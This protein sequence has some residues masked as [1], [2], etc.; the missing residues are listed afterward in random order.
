MARASW[1]NVGVDYSSFFSDLYRSE[2]AKK[3]ETQAAADADARSRWAAGQMSDTEWLAY[4]A[5]RI[6][7]TV[8]DPSEHQKWVSLQRQ[9]TISIADAHA[10]SAYQQSGDLAAYIGYLESAAAGMSPGSQEYADRQAQ[11]A[12]YKDELF[13]QDLGK[14]RDEIV[15]RINEGDVSGYKDLVDLLVE[16]KSRARPGSP[17]STDIDN[18]LSTARSQQR[19]VQAKGGA[20]EI[21][22]LFLEN[23]ITGAEAARRLR[24][25]AETYYKADPVS[26]YKTR[27]NALEYAKYGN[28]FYKK[29]APSSGGSRSGGTSRSGSSG[30][31]SVNN[32]ALR[33]AG[34]DRAEYIQGLINNASPENPVIRIDG[35]SYSVFN[36]D[37]TYAAWVDEFHTQALGAYDLLATEQEASSK[38]S[39]RNKAGDTRAAKTKFI[40]K[41]VQPGN[42]LIGERI[43][44]Q[45]F[46]GYQKDLAEAQKSNDPRSTLN[47][48]ET[49]RNNLL[50]YRTRVTKTRNDKSVREDGR[51]DGSQNQWRSI[52]S[53]SPSA[54]TNQHINEVNAAIDL[55]TAALGGDPDLDNTKDVINSRYNLPDKAKF[56]PSKVMSS[57]LK[58]VSETAQDVACLDRGECALVMTP[59]GTVVVGSEPVTKYDATT[60]RTTVVMQPSKTKMN[61][62]LAKEG[63]VEF[64]DTYVQ[65]NGTLM[66]VPTVATP[67]VAGKAYRT[68]D[69]LTYKDEKGKSHVLPK[70]AL[71][72]SS[73][74][75]STKNDFEA[76]RRDRKV[77]LA[78]APSDWLVVTVP[79]SQDGHD[80][81]PTVQF[82]VDPRTGAWFDANSGAVQPR[83]AADATTVQVDEFG[84]VVMDLAAGASGA[85]MPSGFVG[86]DAR[87]MAAYVRAHPDEF[88]N[89]KTYDATGNA[90]PQ[91]GDWGRTYDLDLG[92]D[93]R[94]P[95]RDERDD[96]Y[97]L[98]QAQA[99]K[100]VEDARQAARLAA[101]KPPNVNAST[102]FN[103]NAAVGFEGLAN[104]LGITFGT[105]RVNPRFG[106]G[107]EA[108]G[109]PTGPSRASS[110][111]V[112]PA[113]PGAYDNVSS[114]PVVAGTGSQVTLK[115]TD[116]T[117]GKITLPTTK[118]TTTPT[119]TVSSSTGFT[120]P[121]TTGT[122][123]VNSSTGFVTGSKTTTSSKTTTAS[124]ITTPKATPKPTPKATTTTTSSR[125]GGK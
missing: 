69:K 25:L 23:K 108:L 59:R 122:P 96:A 30:G 41:N 125:R 19:D 4:I 110:P 8:D 123:V 100:R 66:K 91:T 63:G 61:E 85:A 90:I 32:I 120:V 72:P 101:S 115:P 50:A 27:D 9:D 7:A 20:A 73:L 68:N 35:E 116:S 112:A 106:A 46:G 98:S 1:G 18:W 103:M 74:L 111:T 47:A 107:R 57:T 52:P 45:I 56:I 86:K 21:N 36:P 121:K 60:G 70:G 38:A 117:V 84:H 3:D 2:K 99:K 17:I 88:A 82:L 5:A 33:Q 105:K 58:D 81:Y 15:N 48:T 119:T 79:A 43:L 92:H 78:D 53:D 55:V 54:M 67:F 51:N 12:K 31:G 6:A 29:G 75:T 26:Y 76:W 28:N 71:V 11:I 97:W 44:G 124:K 13:S 89:V 24:K 114:G 109:L 94:P 83:S 113:V 14:R 80:T 22:N 77:A 95:M 42:A 64:A 87:L 37:G 62:I 39:T 16:A 40:V 102:G 10:A 65:M 118:T 104:D 93:S 49:L 34:V